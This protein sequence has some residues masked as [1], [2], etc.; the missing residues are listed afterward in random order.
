M[1]CIYYS[2]TIILAPTL[3]LYSK[4]TVS[5]FTSEGEALFGQL[6]EALRRRLHLSDLSHVLVLLRTAALQ[7]R[8][9][10]L[11]VFHPVRSELVARR[12][13]AAV[14]EDHALTDIVAVELPREVE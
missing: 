10:D 11:P 14:S 6:I 8:P 1:K 5:N 12:F 13:R 9:D 4:S 7:E 2:H 3:K